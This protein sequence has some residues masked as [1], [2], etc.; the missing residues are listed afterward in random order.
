MTSAITK[1]NQMADERAGGGGG[2]GAGSGGVGGIGAGLK[3]DETKAVAVVE[4]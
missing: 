2:A 3:G 4:L 1:G